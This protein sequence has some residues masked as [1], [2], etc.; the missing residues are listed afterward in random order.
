[1][2]SELNEVGV[3]LGWS[4]ESVAGR[5]VSLAIV[6]SGVDTDRLVIFGSLGLSSDTNL[7]GTSLAVRTFSVKGRKTPVD[8]ET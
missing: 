3:N 4:R 2:N 6:I 8:S 5:S 1:M 7:L